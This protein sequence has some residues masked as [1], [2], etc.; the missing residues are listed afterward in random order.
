MGGRAAEVWD[1]FRV[2]RRAYPLDLNIAEGGAATVV[3]A[4]HDVTVQAGG[5]D[6]CR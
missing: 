6:R 5:I 3:T 1:G 2:G 4:A